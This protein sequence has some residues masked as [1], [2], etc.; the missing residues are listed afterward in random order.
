MS[1]LPEQ[2]QREE[3]GLGTPGD[4]DAREFWPLEPWPSE[5]VAADAAP[6]EMLAGA[7]VAEPALLAEGEA[8]SDAPLFESVTRPNVAPVVRIPH[9]GHLA[10]LVL[11]L[12]IGFVGDMIAMPVAL[13]YHLFGISN[14]DQASSEIH[15]TLG[16]EALI[17]LITLAGCVLIFPLLWHKRFFDGVAWRGATAL[18]LKGMLVGA[19]FICFLLALLNG[20]LMPGPENAPIDKIFRTPGAA[21]LLFGFGV[22]IAP[23]FEELMFRGFLLPS[24][25]TACDWISALVATFVARGTLDFTTISIASERLR[26][27]DADGQPQW[28]M[29]AMVIASVLTS[30]PFAGMHAEQTGYSLGP[31]LLLACVSMVLCAVRLG[32]RSLAASVVV[33]ASY[34]FMLFSFML[35]GTGGF[36]HL[37]NM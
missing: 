15:Y 32:A 17:Y 1:E 23:F 33:H 4:A 5:P 19:A 29:T 37:E 11:M 30:I 26:P 34:N 12:L 16:S 2:T 7:P 8:A 18:R 28:S 24:L 20:W 25:C 14:A 9:L 35:W 27:L 21:W 36:K 13:H 10:L 31:F 6:A 22:T 3:E